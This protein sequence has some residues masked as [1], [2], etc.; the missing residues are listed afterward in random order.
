VESRPNLTR[1]GLCAA[2]LDALFDC[3]LISFVDDGMMLVAAEIAAELNPLKLPDKLCR[4]PTKEERQ[5][6]AYHRRYLFS[7]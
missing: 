5:F 3:G 6:L 7:A 1:D 2:H 4:E